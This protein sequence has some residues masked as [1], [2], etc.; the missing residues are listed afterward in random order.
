MESVTTVSCVMNSYDFLDSAN[1]LREMLL[2]LLFASPLG[3]WLDL[4]SQHTV[5]M[6]DCALHGVS[7][8]SMSLYPRDIYYSTTVLDWMTGME[9]PSYLYN[10]AQRTPSACA[11]RSK[12]KT[13]WSLVCPC[14]SIKA[15]SNQ[16]RTDP[17]Q[18]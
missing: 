16:A 15:A 5:S 17:Q 1:L 13:E 10:T 18:K 7:Q 11:N 14:I 12:N 6:C 8:V 9:V 2:Q 4:P 3:P